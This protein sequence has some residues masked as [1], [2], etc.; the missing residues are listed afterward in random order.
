MKIL[1]VNKFLYLNGGSE[2]YVFKI[3]EYLTSIGH[4]VQY[5]G[6]KDYRNIVGN[7][8]ESYTSNFDFHA[9]KLKKIMYP[10]KIIYSAEARKKIRKILKDFKPDIV[11]LN[12]FNFQITPSIIYEIKNCNIPIV[13]TAHDYQLICPNHMLYDLRTKAPCEKCLNGTYRQCSKNKCI[14]GSMIKSIF[15]TIEA[16][17]Y[18]M[19][20]TYSYIDKVICPSEFLENKIK[21]NSNLNGR[22]I[23]LHN[24]ID[25]IESRHIKKE[26]YV[27]YFGRF[28]EEKG[29]RTLVEVCNEMP[30]IQFVFVGKGELENMINKVTNIKNI[31]FKKGLELEY[32]IRKAKL[33]IY[34]SEWYEN[35]PFS[36]MESQMYGTPV[37]GADIG[38]IPELI[39][40]HK[41]G[42]LYES[43]NREDL[44]E[45]I[46][47]LWNNNFII[48]E[49]SRNC[50]DVEFDTID[51]YCSKLLRIYDECILKHIKIVC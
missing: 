5:F 40:N 50:K 47:H 36:V 21:H 3:G 6:M 28:S 46:G 17:L 48:E 42:E 24:F 26:N 16:T 51:K 18:S 12:N 30:E 33:S 2:T 9:G 7:N 10:F 15:G 19:L 34:P 11:H 37:I 32:Y 44:K 31:G 25:Q 27:I 1:M 13:F 43:G 4:E 22:T 49:Y 23:I 35:C 14:H 29:I 41:T 45:K 39:K 8:V 20:R 38:G